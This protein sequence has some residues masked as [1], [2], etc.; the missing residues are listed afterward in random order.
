MY[1]F[2]IGIIHN[3]F[4]YREYDSISSFTNMCNVLYN[5]IY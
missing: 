1:F 5:F 2:Y 3:I 4:A